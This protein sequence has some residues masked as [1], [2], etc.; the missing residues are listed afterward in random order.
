VVDDDP[1][2]LKALA[3]LLKS[4]GHRV[5]AFPGPEAFLAAHDAATPGCLV[6]D[7]D[8]PAINGLELQRRLAES[9]SCRAIVF[10]SGQADV[11]ESVQAMKAGAVDFLRKPFEDSELLQAVDMAIRR[12]RAARQASDERW[13]PGASTR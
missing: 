9:D 7:V 12:G 3:R 13:W 2:V 1:G 5:E 4:A 8:M 6:L 10:I 11:P